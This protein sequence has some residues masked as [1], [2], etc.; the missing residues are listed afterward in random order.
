M[1]DR[2]KRLLA[3]LLAGVAASILIQLHFMGHKYILTNSNINM[4]C[5]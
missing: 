2:Q 1:S 3:G 5:I 4:E